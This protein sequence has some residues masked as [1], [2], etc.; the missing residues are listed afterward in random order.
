[1]KKKAQRAEKKEGHMRDKS[2]A[3]EN[4]R[5]TRSPKKEEKQKEKV[6][7]MHAKMPR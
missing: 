3:V 5:A 2:K 6:G 7:C 4:I 1:V